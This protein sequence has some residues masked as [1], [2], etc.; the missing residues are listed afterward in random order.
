M[1]REEIDKLV[2][3]VENKKENE[4]YFKSLSKLL[5]KGKFS[6]AELIFDDFIDTMEI[7]NFVNKMEVII[8]AIE[9]GRNNR[10]VEFEPSDNGE[11]L[12]NLSKSIDSFSKNFTFN[13][14]IKKDSNVDKEAILIYHITQT[15]Y[16]ALQLDNKI[17]LMKQNS[18]DIEEINDLLNNFINKYTDYDSYNKHIDWREIDVKTLQ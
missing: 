9:E 12:I 17:V 18:E 2:E 16:Y 10:I 8:N 13:D 4:T 6:A 14:D 1:T 11:L 5:K 7:G 15:I 3:E